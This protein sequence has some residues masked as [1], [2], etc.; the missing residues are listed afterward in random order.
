MRIY[1]CDLCNESVP[2]GDL[3]AG[4]AVLRKGRVVCRTCEAAMSAG[5][6]PTEAA[7]RAGGP[8]GG[9]GGASGATRSVGTGGGAAGTGLHASA[10]THAA[11]SSSGAAVAVALASVALL[12]AVGAGLFA[13]TQAERSGEL[14]DRRVADQVALMRRERDQLLS[15]F[16]TRLDERVRALD[17]ARVAAER[18]VAELGA[19]TDELGGRQ[20]EAL[21][22]VRLELSA[23]DGRIDALET[24][25]ANVDRHEQ[26]LARVSDAIA[27]LRTDVA[28]ASDRLAAVPTPSAEAP[29]AAAPSREA[30]RPEW[31]HWVEAL[32]SAEAGDRWVAVQ[33]LGD[34]RDPKVAEHLTPMLQDPDIFVR[35]A[36]ARILGD[37]DAVVGI[38]A[39]IDALED[40][41]ASVR[42][43]AVVA[44]RA[45]TGQSF[46]F[47]PA[48]KD[49]AERAKRVKAWRDWWNKAADQYLG[50]APSGE[51]A[52]G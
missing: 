11:P 28:R 37:L 36:T 35:M 24:I 12:L 21:Q 6:A 22:E 1:F 48:S 34:T 5:D 23:I 50:R 19:R 47:D 49:A 20:R 32:A 13:F 33:S 46:R 52:G 18:G 41:E 8:S 10:T 3:D 9:G 31:W 14:V 4:K 17:D 16:N 51:R 45:I 27:G 15:G 40:P 2:Q 30:E 39:L 42:E 7:A 38:P 26:A 43:A 29:A 25:A 44:L